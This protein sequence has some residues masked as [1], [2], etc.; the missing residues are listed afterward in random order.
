M[1]AGEGDGGADGAD[2]CHFGECHQQPAV[3]AIV[4]GRCNAT[5]NQRANPVSGLPLGGAITPV[6]FG[7]MLDAGLPWL[8]LPTVALLLVA[9]LLCMGT[10]RGEALRQSRAPV[11]LPAE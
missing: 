11:P 1:S 2:Y 5:L 10:A 6:P 7:L 9:S 4:D 3:G 8:V